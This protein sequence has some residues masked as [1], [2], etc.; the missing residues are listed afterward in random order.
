M[1]TITRW[2]MGDGTILKQVGWISYGQFYPLIMWP[3]R[4]NTEC[5]P[6]YAHVPAYKEHSL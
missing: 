6:V 4:P 3:T 1:A 5:F 2:D